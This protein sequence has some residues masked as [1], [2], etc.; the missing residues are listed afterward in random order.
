ME[1]LQGQLARALYLRVGNS[2]CSDIPNAIE[3]ID[4]VGPPPRLRSIVGMPLP[5]MVCRTHFKRRFSKRAIST[6]PYYVLH[7]TSTP[8]GHIADYGVALVEGT[9]VQ[10]TLNPSAA[11]SCGDI[12]E[13]CVETFERVSWKR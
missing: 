8:S 11:V 13:V 2:I 6:L 10:V 1:E 3:T 7:F 5:G 4:V 12:V 9:Q